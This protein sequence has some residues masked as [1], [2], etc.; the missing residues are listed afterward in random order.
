MGKKKVKVPA[1]VPQSPFDEAVDILATILE[2]CGVWKSSS[3]GEDDWDRLSS[4]LQAFVAA[5]ESSKKASLH[6]DSSEQEQDDILLDV[7]QAAQSLHSSCESFGAY[8]QNRSELIDLCQDLDSFCDGCQDS[9][10]I[11]IVS[12]AL[13]GAIRQQ[14]FTAIDAVKSILQTLSHLHMPEASSRQQYSSLSTQVHH[15]LT[16]IQRRC[17][18]P[19]SPPWTEAVELLKQIQPDHQSLDFLERFG[20]SKGRTPEDES[21]GK[22]L[23]DS[24][25]PTELLKKES[26]TVVGAVRDFLTL[27][28]NLRFTK[29][30]LLLVVGPEGSGKTYLCNEIQGLVGSNACG[31]FVHGFVPALW[32][33]L[34]IELTLY[35]NAQLFDRRFRLIQWENQS[36]LLRII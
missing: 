17:I 19:K 26:P 12:R 27:E 13:M 30:S 28:G 6:E 33:L 23:E 29:P 5:I 34:C 15:F 24:S 14:T 22:T 10:R 3:G 2:E 8:I 16:L 9:I 36:A 35:L 25:R 18:D 7:E 32:M 11:R 4:V 1:V 21:I 20:L 31:K